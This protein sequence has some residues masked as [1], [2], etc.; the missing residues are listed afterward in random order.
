MSSNI[1]ISES[2]LLIM[3]IIWNNHDSI[4]FGEL[5]QELKTDNNQWKPN[6]VLTFLSRLIDKEIIEIKKQGR[7]N[8]YIALMSKEDYLRA[9]T[10]NFINKVYGGNI[11]GL[12][13][14]LIKNN[15]ID[16]K[17]FEE[18]KDF[19]EKEENR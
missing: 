7:L 14:N 3:E 6:T 17:D 2:E 4:M 8:Q 15:N 16:A 10:D 1:Q 12:M 13:T 11:K 19:W 18:I 9:T 5:M